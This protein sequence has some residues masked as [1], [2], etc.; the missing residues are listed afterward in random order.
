MPAGAGTGAL[1]ACGAVVGAVTRPSG[2]V[3]RF[4]VA[5]LRALFRLSG[6][7]GPDMAIG[8]ERPA[9]STSSLLLV[10]LIEPRLAIL[11]D[12]LTR[13]W[14]NCRILED[15][16]VCVRTGGDSTVPDKGSG[17]ITWGCSWA[18][19]VISGWPGSSSWLLVKSD[20]ASELELLLVYP[21][22]VP[23]R[24]VNMFLCYWDCRRV[25]G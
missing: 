2:S 24:V 22:D 14:F 15:D 19:R 17:A 18:S 6:M 16:G 20:S 9:G 13:S 5:V 7:P 10:G 3:S 25:I 23:L 21:K 8:C 11:S 12:R 4:W 1:A